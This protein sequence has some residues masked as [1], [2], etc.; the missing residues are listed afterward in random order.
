M[1]NIVKSREGVQQLELTDEQ[2]EK[3]NSYAQKGNDEVEI[4]NFEHAIGWFNKAMEVLPEPK[5]AWLAT[6]WLS[7]C[8]GDACFNLHKYREA[9]KYL[10]LAKE[11]YGPNDANPF[12]LLRLG[13]CYYH[14]NKE[15]DAKEYLLNTY[16]LEGPDMF[17]D[18][19]L[20]FDFLKSKVL[21]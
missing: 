10:L 17:V 3:I 2:E 14:L 15:E 5:K 9:V 18:E 11:V 1:N 7:A 4:E 12:V 13:Q 20:Y 21:L 8:I 19:P 16:M 6:G